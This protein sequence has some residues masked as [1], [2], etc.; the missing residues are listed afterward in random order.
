MKNLAVLGVLLTDDGKKI[1]DEQLSWLNTEFDVTCIEQ[2]PPGKEFEYPAIKYTAEL[3]VNTNKPVLYIHTKGAANPIPGWSARM[4]NKKFN[5]PSSARPE[6]CQKV[7]RNL[8]ENEFTGERLEEY[9]SNCNTDKPTVCC[10][11]TGKEKWTW[12]N[13]WI[14]N[15]SA[16]KILLTKLKQTDYRWYYERIFADIKEISVI[17]MRMNDLYSN[18]LDN[19]KSFWD[20]IWQFYKEE[21]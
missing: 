9:I 1:K 4:M 17:G 5:V 7:I 21:K 12:W 15:P 16:A 13:A 6:D 8:W 2:E 14:I 20:D 10:P 19:T 11:Y 18:T 3:S